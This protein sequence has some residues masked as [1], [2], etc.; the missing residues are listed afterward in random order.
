MRIA[1]IGSGISGIAA[2]AVLQR[3]GHEVVVFEREAEPGG[4]WARTY[5]N[6]TLQN[7]ASQYHISD[8]PWPF[9]PDLHPTA[10][11]IR[12]Y[13]AAAIEYFELDIRT[14]HAIERL[15]QLERGESGWRIH[16]RGPNGAFEL[17]FEFVLLAVGQ[18]T[19][20]KSPA[21]QRLPGRERYRGRILSE[22]DVRDPQLFAGKRVAVI[23]F[24]KTA[25]DMATMAAEAGA[26]SV[27]HV[28]RTSRWL[29]P[30]YLFGIHMSYA[31]FA[32]HGSVMLPSWVHPS[33]PER[34]LHE[35]LGFVVRGFWSML[36]RVVWTQHLRDA[37][38]RD[39]QAHE[40][41]AKLRPEHGVVPDLRS[42]AAIA[43]RNYFRLVAEGKIDPVRA[44]LVG[45][46]ETGV[47]LG[48]VEGSSAEPPAELPAELVVLALGSGSPVFP[49]LPQRY[50]DLLEREPDGPQL[51]R[52]L[53]DPRIPNLAFAGYNH[54]FLHVPSVELASLWLSAMLRGELELPPPERMLAAIESIRTWKRANIAFEPSRSCATSTRFHQYLDV[55]LGDL[56][57]SPYRKSNPLAELFARY[58]SADYAGVIDELNRERDKRPLRRRAL[59]FET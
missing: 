31:L 23:G 59:D 54:G 13:L 55:L 5:P 24:G 29:I 16:G 4:V 36:A 7:I 38:P 39:R 43:P 10:D 58:G 19:Q 11:Q 45:F 20:P 9:E 8:F 47:R 46:D 56:G 41:I 15:E 49:F 37:K 50:R 1:V 53:L 26:S 14:S 3:E 33:G 35:R 51:Y 12:R 18:Y 17:E 42:A 32:R 2:A 25:V 57:L 6:V 34:F 21:W 30:V 48:P 52:H 22:L 44:E 28:F 27:S 40:R